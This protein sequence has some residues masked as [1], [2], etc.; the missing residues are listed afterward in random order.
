MSTTTVTPKDQQISDPPRKMGTIT[1]RYSLIF[2]LDQPEIIDLDVSEDDQSHS[3][4]ESGS[5]YPDIN[6]K[7]NEREGTCV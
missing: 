7:I 2:N 1:V 3:N 4:V 6:P 5:E